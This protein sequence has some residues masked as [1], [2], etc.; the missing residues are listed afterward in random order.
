MTRLIRPRHPEWPPAL[1]E[2]VRP[3]VKQLY[4]EGIRL[5][6]SASCIAIVGTRRPTAAGLYAATQIATGLSIE[7]YTIVSGLAVGIDAAA[8]RAT[9]EAGGRTVAVLGCGHDID[10]PKR[11]R[12]LRRAIEIEGTVVSEYPP[13]LEPKP[14]MFPARNRIIAGLSQAVVVVE[15]SIK[16]GALVTA[17]LALDANREVFAV[18][19]S[20]R[21]PM[22]VGPNE[23]IRRG[24]AALVTRVEQVVEG[25]GAVLACSATSSSPAAPMLLGDREAAVLSLLDDVPE[26]PDVFARTLDLS[27]GEIAS[28]LSMLE[29]KGLARRTY[30]G[31]VIT[32]AGA[33]QRGS[34]AYEPRELRHQTEAQSHDAHVART[35]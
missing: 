4:V 16:S 13:E 27:A 11:N 33:A 15:G 3:R 20:V 25:L 17:R 19:G 21:N 9:L 10:Y 35:D 18:P 29:L 7:G 8:H 32:D 24:E 34:G 2:E 31:H 14:S 5:D 23:L 26:G 12:T 22:A 1:D 6:P 28:A 30:R